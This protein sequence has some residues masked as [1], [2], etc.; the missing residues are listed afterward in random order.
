MPLT[1]VSSGVIAANAVVDSFGTQSITGDKLGLTA[2][3][4]NNIVNA[5]ITGAKIALGTI[6]GD[7]IAT[8][9]ITGN[10]L[11]DNCVSGNNIVSSPTITG[12]VT[13]NGSL[14]IGGAT[15]PSSGVGIKFP[16]TQVGSTDAN[17]LDD[18]EEGTWTPSVGGDATYTGR[19]AEYTKIGN[20]I[21]VRAE[22]VISVIG[23]GS[24]TV[25]G[26]LP[27]SAAKECTISLSKLG[28]SS[29]NFYSAQL[30][31][32]GSDLYIS[33]QTNLDG[34]IDVNQNFMQ[35]GT[36]VQFSGVYRI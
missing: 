12:N 7:D 16:A 36:E 6:T 32:S 13:I 22:M 27:F 4:A 24:A 35:N 15:T 25:I 5:S 31:N 23:T 26:G 28:N 10:L 3:N 20:L 1:K 9:Q 2:I 30:R 34:T 33:A 21:F 14:G 19:S 11:T 18:Y 17:T 29:L 8:G